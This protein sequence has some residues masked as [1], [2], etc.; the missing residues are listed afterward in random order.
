MEQLLVDYGQYVVIF[1]AVMGV[2]S[3]IARVTPNKSDD[4]IV[5]AIWKFV[6]TLGLRG[7]PT[8]CLIFAILITG[9]AH[10]HLERFD[11]ETGR[12]ILE[13]ESFVIGGGTTEQIFNDYT[14]S[15][16]ETGL[17][18]NGLALGKAAAVAASSATAPGA[19]ATIGKA[20][21]S[22]Q[23]ESEID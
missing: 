1:M 20:I 11:P 21:F 10:G 22:D 19:V 13:A 8:L 6:N 7:G 23:E 4:K 12:K 17:S 18:D 15:T 3:A 5:N 16:R 2:A 9:C 14:Y